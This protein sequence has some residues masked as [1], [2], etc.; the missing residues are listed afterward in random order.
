V[1]GGQ[2]AH[3]PSCSMWGS[4][5]AGLIKWVGRGLIKWVG[6]SCLLPSRWAVSWSALRGRP[7]ARARGMQGLRCAGS[8][9]ETCAL[10]NGMVSSVVGRRHY[11][12]C[13]FLVKGAGSTCKHVNLQGPCAP[14]NLH[15]NV[16][17]CMITQGAQLPQDV[18]N[19][20]RHSAWAW[21]VPSCV[22]GYAPSGARNSRPHHAQLLPAVGLNARAVFVPDVAMLIPLVPPPPLHA[23]PLARSQQ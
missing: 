14:Q 6:R 3:A 15:R 16:S 18:Q 7:C 8:A 11:E 22:I 19:V 5:W 4:G 9:R 13:Q 1:G 17:A 21:K 12:H 20:M 23:I 2:R 10:A